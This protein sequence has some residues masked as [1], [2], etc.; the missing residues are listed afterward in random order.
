[1]NQ[2]DSIEYLTFSDTILPVVYFCSDKTVS[3]EATVRQRSSVSVL[4][5]SVFLNKS[6]V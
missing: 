1:M 6:V 5:E 2:I 3:K 4:N